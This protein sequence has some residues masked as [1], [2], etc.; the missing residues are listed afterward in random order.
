MEKTLLDLAERE[1]EA[2]FLFRSF[3]WCPTSTV[4]RLTLLGHAG[5]VW[6]F[7]NLLH[8]DMGYRISNLRM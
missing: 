2:G 1:P 8:W 4:G 5:L 3:V 6:C 7:H